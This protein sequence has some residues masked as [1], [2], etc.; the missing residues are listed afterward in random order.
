[1]EEKIVMNLFLISIIILIF[2][3]L[4]VLI[5]IIREN[6]RLKLELKLMRICLLKELHYDNNDLH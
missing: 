1:M 6:N 4:V 2:I 5:S 3:L